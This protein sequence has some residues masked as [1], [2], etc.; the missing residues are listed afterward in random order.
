MPRV[1]LRNGALAALLCLLPRLAHADG[2]LNIR[3]D[4]TQADVKGGATSVGLAWPGIEVE[5]EKAF[6]TSKIV[7]SGFAL[8]VRREAFSGFSAFGQT[9]GVQRWD[10]GTYLMLRVYRSFTVPHNRSWS[11]SPSLAFFYGIPG[12]T[13][14]R[15]KTT[16]RADG[17]FDYTHI[18]PMRNADVPKTLAD[19]ADVRTGSAVVYPEASLS[20][21]KRKGGLMLEWIASARVIRFGVIDSGEQGFHFEERR[22]VT[23]SVGM[24]MGFRLF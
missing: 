20:F 19:Q 12:T 13:L 3:F 23:P 1:L 24:R 11:I 8:G 4:V 21:R 14:D 10:E 16:L 2:R 7:A 18:Y 15:T 17:G 6:K 5:L 9:T 22:T